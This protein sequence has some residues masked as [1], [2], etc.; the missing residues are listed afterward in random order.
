[1]PLRMGTVLFLNGMFYRYLLS[2]SG[3]I[4]HLSPLFPYWF[5]SDLFINVTG[6]FKFS[7]II[8]LLS[9]SPFMSINIYFIY[10]GAPVL[11]VYILTSLISSS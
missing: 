2:P 7:I 9:I 4:C 3:L 6:V 10:L 8:L 5:L 1:M 11:C